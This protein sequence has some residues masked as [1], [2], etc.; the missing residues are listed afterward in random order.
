M[1][2]TYFQLLDDK[3]PSDSIPNIESSSWML[4]TRCLT[5]H[6]SFI[7]QVLP[8]SINNMDFVEVSY[9]IM[10]YGETEIC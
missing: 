10:V 8:M 5:H 4:S 9:V 2:A 6:N 7:F 3:V 1:L